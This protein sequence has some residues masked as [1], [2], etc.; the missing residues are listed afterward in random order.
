MKKEP[1]HLFYVMPHDKKTVLYVCL[2][3]NKREAKTWWRQCLRSNVK[4]EQFRVAL[5]INSR[6]YTMQLNKSFWAY[7]EAYACFA[8]LRQS[9]WGP[10][11]QDATQEG[12]KCNTMNMDGYHV[13]SNR[14]VNAE[15]T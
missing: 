9:L 5:R 7:E 11:Y 10:V 1:Y 13:E 3:H 8:A 4:S 12:N 6:R 2:A 14:L 15:A